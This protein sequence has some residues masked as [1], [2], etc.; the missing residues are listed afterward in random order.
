MEPMDCALQGGPFGRDHVVLTGPAGPE[1]LW[2]LVW[3][4][5]AHVLVSL[6]PPNAQEKVRGEEG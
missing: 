4:H 6:C 2:E 3:E 5:G 1:E